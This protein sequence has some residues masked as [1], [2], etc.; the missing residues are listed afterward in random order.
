MK[1]R[2]DLVLGEIRLRRQSNKRLLVAVSG[3]PA[4]GKSTFSEMLLE[5]LTQI[6]GQETAACVVPMDG[7]HLDNSQLDRLGLRARKGAP[8][9]FDF[10]GFHSLLERIRA[11]RRPVYYPVFD[12]AR[13]LAVAG[14]GVVLPE[15]EIVIVEGNYLMLDDDPWAALA[16]LF[17]LEIFLDTP[18]TLLEK[19]LIQRWLDHGHDPEAARNRAQSN[20][21]PNAERVL[22]SIRRSPN[23]MVLPGE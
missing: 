6:D 18:A 10:D 23:A 19:R 3:P 13:D 8:S 2:I 5:A 17:D 15:T 21:I 4:T 20:D 9:T 22:A 16:P 1:D 7:F 12:R 11:T 14:A